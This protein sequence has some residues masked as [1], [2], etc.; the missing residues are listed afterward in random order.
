[1][2]A[3]AELPIFP[4]GTVLF[5]GG[6]LALR[7]FEPRYVEMTKVCLR[8]NQPFGVALIRAGFEVGKPAVPCE[9]GCT[10]RI[11]DWEMPA[12]NQ[13][14]LMA[15]GECRFRIER[16]WVQADGLLMAQVR[17]IE[18]A[19]PQGLPPRYT[20]M[21]QLLS[22][23]MQELGAENFPQP[24]RLDDASWVASRLCELLPLPPERKQQL[25]EL[26]QPL[27]QLR[28]VETWLREL[29]E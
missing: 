27:E 6:R 5:P 28:M 13:F 22:R 29:P 24:P 20:V 15:R 18:P 3:P 2:T 26:D 14:T 21:A 17:L 23:L 1:M 9:L 4:L 16:R 10:A 7:I 19:D 25:L 11:T 12:P 8:D